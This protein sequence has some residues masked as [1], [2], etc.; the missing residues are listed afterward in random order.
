MGI[1]IE[2]KFLVAGDAWRAQALRSQRMLQ[3]YLIDADIVQAQAGTRCS[4]RVRIGGEQAWLNIK[5]ANLGI[6]RQEYEYAI[7]VADAER[8]LRDFCNG[9]IEKVRHYV[10]YAGLTYEVDEFF[11]E[12]AG[13]VVAELEL[14][15][16][17]QVFAKPDWLGREV[18]DRLRYYNLHLL[19]HPYSRWDE[20]ERAGD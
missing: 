19:Q 8:M 11:G 14:D 7:P 9:A 12:N 3:G 15:A 18:S 1:E 2:R 10:P 4:L 5:S 20:R 13:L 6:A 16:V 17:D